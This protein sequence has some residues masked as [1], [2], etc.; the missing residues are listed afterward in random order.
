MYQMYHK[1]LKPILFKADSRIPNLI[2]LC[3]LVV[4]QLYNNMTKYHNLKL[5]FKMG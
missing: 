1:S 3:L 4:G 5:N 2:W